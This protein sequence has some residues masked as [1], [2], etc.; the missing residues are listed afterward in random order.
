MKAI[1][2]LMQRRPTVF[3]QRRYLRAVCEQGPCYSSVSIRRRPKQQ[4]PAILVGG[5]HV[6]MASEQRQRHIRMSRL[7]CKVQWRGACM[8]G[9]VD[10]SL[11]FQQHF[12]HRAMSVVRSDTEWPSTIGILRRCVTPSLMGRKGGPLQ[13]HLPERLGSAT[14]LCPRVAPACSA[15]E[16]VNLSARSTAA[17]WSSSRATIGA[18][19]PSAAKWRAGQSLGPDR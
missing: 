12:H 11:V 16:S 8:C 6:R 13:Q 4:R 3:V 9:R 1:N 18:C 2:H 15:V 7:C 19:P 5:V 14:V 10:L 17:P